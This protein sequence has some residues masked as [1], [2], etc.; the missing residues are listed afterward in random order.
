MTEGV[1]L[2]TDFTPDHSSSGSASTRTGRGIAFEAV[3]NV[4]DFRGLPTSDGFQVSPRKLFRGGN[5][6]H[7]TQNDMAVL[8]ALRLNV[9]VDLRSTTEKPA[10]EQAFDQAMPREAQPVF[11]AN[12]SMENL[13]RSLRG[14]T[15][16]DASA[17]MIDL[18]ERL[19]REGTASFRALFKHAE[20]GET[21]LFHCTAGKDRT[22]FAAALLLMALGVDDVAIR[23]DYLE[24]NR[25]NL[26]FNEAARAVAVRE[27]VDPDVVGPL[28]EVREAYLDAGL[29]AIVREHGTIARFLRDALQADIEAIRRHYLVA[30]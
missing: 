25:A 12:F 1:T 23:A 26:R 27:Q 10:A 22:G 4:R 11:G 24:S 13:M 28:L 6:A 16:D 2:A 17:L 5:P 19:A 8:R 29:H 7:A 3:H 15:P 18:Y 21:L 14:R 30:L 20:R 9:I